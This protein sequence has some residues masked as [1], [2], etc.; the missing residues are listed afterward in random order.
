MKKKRIPWDQYFMLQAILVASRSTCERLSVG[1]VLVRN[2]RV[3]A[4]GYNGSVSG[5]VHCIDEGCY[6]VDG[7]C[8]RTIHAEMNAILQCAK[9]GESTDDAEIY[10]TDF[11]CLQCTKMLLQA[12]I[13]TIKYLR[14]YRN[15]KYAEAL[16]K[17]GHVKVEKVQ[18]EREQVDNLP[19]SEYL[20][21]DK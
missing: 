4:C 19:F 3:I 13:K 12:G 15:S 6:M 1:S 8:Q 2:K 9:F 17:K 7:H 5:D 18:I 14:E 21:F 20:S 10:V 11:P 16:L